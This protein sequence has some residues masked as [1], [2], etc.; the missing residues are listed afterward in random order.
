MTRENDLRLNERLGLLRA[1]C[2]QH[3]HLDAGELHRREVHR[4]AAATHYGEDALP[5]PSAVAFECWG[6]QPIVAGMLAEPKRVAALP[7]I[8]FAAAAQQ[9]MGAHAIDILIVLIA[10]DGSREKPE[11]A[12]VAAMIEDDDRICRK[13]VWLPGD[14]PI[15]SAEPFLSRSP[16]ARPWRGA[17]P[18]TAQVRTL[19]NLVRESDPLD[20]LAIRAQADGLSHEEFLQRAL[21]GGN[22]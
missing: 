20:E 1:V 15:E 14:N 7:F 22:L 16:F 4:E 6:T 8:R 2:E 19:D 12:R 11:W 5:P 18:I 17:T 10:P 21:E 9:T 3:A 13:L